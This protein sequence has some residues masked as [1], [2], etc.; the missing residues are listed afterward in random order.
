[1]T[2]ST[3]GR[4]GTAPGVGTVAEEAARLVDLLSELTGLGPAAAGR[5]P[6]ATSGDRAGSPLGRPD[7]DTGDTGGGCTCGGRRPAAC[8]VCP[9]CQVIA[10][11]QRLNPDTV[12][13]LAEVVDLAA[14]G[15]RD[16]A[17]AQ[18]SRREREQG[19]QPAP[20]SEPTG[21]DAPVGEGVR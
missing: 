15:L 20:R 1:M 6:A 18:R 8:T 11:V 13:R 5:G 21:R 14:T 10:F 17:A 9:V 7:D 19:A 16:L 3:N 12:D 2:T 4:D